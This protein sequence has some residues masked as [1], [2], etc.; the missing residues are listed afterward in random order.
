MLSVKISS[1]GAVL[2]IEHLTD[3]RRKGVFSMTWYQD[4]L[5]SYHSKITPPKQLEGN[6]PRDDIV[7]IIDTIPLDK[8][9]CMIAPFGYGKTQTA[10]QWLEKSGFRCAYCCLDD[11]DNRTDLL[12]GALNAAVLSAIGLKNLRTDMLDYRHYHQ[13]PRDFLHKAALSVRVLP[14]SYVLMIKNIHDIKEPDALGCLKDL[15]ESVLGYWKVLIITREKLPPIFNY[16]IMTG[17]IHPITAEELCLESNQ[18]SEFLKRSNLKTSPADIEWIRSQTQGW[19]AALN[20][21]LMTSIEEHNLNYSDYAKSIIADYFEVEIWQGLDDCTHIFL[22][23]TSILDI[24]NPSACYAITDVKD[25]RK[26]LKR[27]YARGIFVFLDKNGQYQYH[28]AF[29]E[30]LQQKLESSNIDTNGLYIKYGEWFYEQKEYTAAFH[31]FYKVKFLYGIDK[32]LKEFNLAIMPMEEFLNVAGCI[33]SLD[34]N[35][36]KQYP[37]IVA[38]MA[39]VE[40]LTGNLERMRELKEIFFEWAEPGVLPIDSDEYTYYCWEGGWLASIDPKETQKNNKYIN[41]MVNFKDYAPHLKVLHDIWSAVMGFPSIF[42]GTKD[43]S[44]LTDDIESF[45]KQVDE[46]DQELIRNEYSLMETRLILAEYYYETERFTKAVK[47]VRMLIPAAA[48]LPYAKLYFCCIA[49][50]V[51]IMRAMDNTDEI[52]D[53]T[54]LLEKKIKEKKSNFLLPNYHAF[55]QRNY[56]ADGNAGFLK[57]FYNENNSL[58]ENNHFYLLYRKIAYVRALISLDKYQKALI[59]LESLEH[60]CEGYLRI[61]DL[62]EVYVLKAIALYYLKDDT[63]A[64]ICLKKAYNTAKQ[65]GYIR[66]FS[67]EAGDLIP[68]LNLLYTENNE[69]YLKTIMISA[70]KNVYGNAPISKRNFYIDLT[71]TELNILKLLQR[72]L[73]YEEI[74]LEHGIKLTTVKKHIQ[75]IYGK[76]GVRNKAEAVAMAIKRGILKD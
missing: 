24:L 15:I 61:V 56:L 31:C 30:F 12:I 43:F 14:G 76:L 64:V 29:K 54:A 53:M 59:I 42:R 35:E 68:I 17:R 75:S 27:L 69:D 38:R 57:E 1:I 62:T 32:I 11:S 66:V 67:D 33:T 13:D 47:Q 65:Y 18:I 19:F 7:K 40:Y 52:G 5:E 8:A 74:S 63:H 48:E 23:K 2:S 22:M 16:L 55:L 9:I 6:L 39:L 58:I 10:L 60:L 72:N 21:I 3:K 41:Y 37:I 70:K 49:L 34:P 4:H 44:E 28:P 45:M 50:L 36:L 46:N 51:K 25:T 73:S 71:K 20:V 26:T